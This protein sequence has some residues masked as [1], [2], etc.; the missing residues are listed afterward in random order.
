MGYL[1]PGMPLAGASIFAFMGAFGLLKPVPFTPS[2]APA[3]RAFPAALVL[4][5]VLSKPWWDYG[6]NPGWAPDLA[7]WGLGA[8]LT[9]LPSL[10]GLGLRV[11]RAALYGAMAA[12]F[13][14]YLPAWGWAWGILLGLAW[15]WLWQRLARP[16]PAR[17]LTYG[18][19]LGFALSYVLHANLQIPF[20]RHL[21]WLGN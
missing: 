7:A 10:R 21:I 15:G 14:A 8:G 13:V 5:L 1:H 17:R 3:P 18:L 12:L 4:G 11:P 19:L 6:A 16:L 9:Y 2:G 20:L